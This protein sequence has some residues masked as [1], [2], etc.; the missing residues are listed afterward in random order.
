[1][2]FYKDFDY[3]VMK[4]PQK[5]SFTK[6]N[7]E[8]YMDTLRTEQASADVPNAEKAVNEIRPKTAVLTNITKGA[9]FYMRKYLDI[10]PKD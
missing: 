2:K 10:N 3:N 4:I 6:K 7:L 9:D 1:M 5:L 8:L